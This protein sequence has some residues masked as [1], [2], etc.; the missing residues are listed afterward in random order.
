MGQK[1]FVI[2]LII[3]V[4]AV[5]VLGAIYTTYHNYNSEPTVP[6]K[7][8]INEG[9]LNTD[10]PKDWKTYTDVK[11]GFEFM[12]PL[13]YQI[14]DFSKLNE[15]SKSNTEGSVYPSSDFALSSGSNIHDYVAIF[16]VVVPLPEI[17]KRSKANYKAK[18]LEDYKANYVSYDNPKGYYSFDVNIHESSPFFINGFSALKQIYSAE[19]SGDIYSEINKDVRYV[20]FDGKSRFI[21]IEGLR[22]SVLFDHI[23]S[24]FKFTTPI[25]T[26]TNPVACT[27]DA[28]QCPDGT[29]VGRTG[30]NCEFA[31]CSTDPIII[32]I[33]PTSGP[34]GTII[35]IRGKN[36]S[37]FEGDLVA[38]FERS[39]GKKTFINSVVPYFAN[40]MTNTTLIEVPVLSPCE[41]GELVYGAYSGIPSKC[42]YFEFTP[43]IYKVYV[44]PWNNKS[45]EVQFTVVK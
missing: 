12:Y 33:S 40:G 15:E 24:T 44:N 19:R 36:L 20:I 21:I 39:D 25:S 35:D 9:I 28:K 10:T 8:L 14:V 27:A 18:T 7:K 38:V 17:D 26:T 2:P 29:Y 42:D 3:A 6:I 13:S 37:G 45:N 5:L 34:V 22:G 30:P 23:V 41:R 11:Y 4:V 1:G 32:S 31:P 43:G 16:D